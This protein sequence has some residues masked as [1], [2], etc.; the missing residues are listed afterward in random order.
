MFTDD[1]SRYT[2]VYSLKIKDEAL[3]KCREFAGLTETQTGHHIKK[4]DVFACKGKETLK[5]YEAIM[6]EYILQRNLLN[7]MQR[8]QGRR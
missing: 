8:R 4:L 2:T 6:V 1:H 3:S 7:T 5:S